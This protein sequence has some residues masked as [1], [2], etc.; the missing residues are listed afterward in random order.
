MRPGPQECR[1]RA[2]YCVK[3]AATTSSPLAREKL[4]HMAEVWLHLADQLEEVWDILDQWG[5]EP[6]AD[7]G[8]SKTPCLRA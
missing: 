7:R 4:T 2:A 3:R 8:V 6:A 1:D 5:Q